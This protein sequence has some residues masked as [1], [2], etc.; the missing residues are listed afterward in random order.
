LTKDAI[1]FSIFRWNCYTI[2]Q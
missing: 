1:I 2:L